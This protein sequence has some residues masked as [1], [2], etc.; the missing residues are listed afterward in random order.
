MDPVLQTYVKLYP[1]STDADSA[2]KIFNRGVTVSNELRFQNIYQL[3]T[4]NCSTSTLNIVD[5]VMGNK[6][7]SF[8][9]RIQGALPL[10]GPIGTL[11]ALSDRHLIG[12]STL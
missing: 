2:S 12:Q 6:D 9:S 1:L 5:A 8:L 3:I 7:S 10:S 11:R 4:N